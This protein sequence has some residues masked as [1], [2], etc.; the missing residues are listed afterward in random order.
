MLSFEN[1]Y[2]K[3]IAQ[4][5]DK[6]GLKGD[7][8]ELI[9]K[10]EIDFTLWL[11]YFTEGIIDELRRLEKLLPKGLRLQDHDKK[12]LGY[13]KRNNSITMR[14]YEKLTL[15]KRATRKKDFKVLVESKILRREGKGRATYYTLYES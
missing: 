3:N 12:I 2:H 11:E 5:F 4:Y 14:D 6:V 13:I 15:R 9:K 1:F 7:Y 8:Y 10:K